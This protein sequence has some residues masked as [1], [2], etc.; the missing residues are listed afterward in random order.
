MGIIMLK[1]LST[2]AINNDFNLP[3]YHQWVKRLHLENAPHHAK[4]WEQ[5]MIYEA[6]KSHGVLKKGS[7]GIGFGV[8]TEPLVSVFAN[9]GAEVLATDQ[10]PE[11]EALAWDNGQLAKGKN[12][13]FDKRLIDK[14]KFDKNVSFEHHDMNT[15]N[16]SWVNKFDFAWSNCVIGHLGSMKLSEKH[17]V[18]HSKYIKYGGVSVLTTEL[19]ISS[20]TETVEDNSGTI[21]WRLSDL[22]RLF[23]RMLDEDMIASRFKLRLIDDE[24]DNY[25]YYEIGTNTPDG[26]YLP[27][28]YI[29]K[30]PFSNYAIVQ[31]QILFKK[32]RLTSAQRSIYRAIY[33]LD[34]ARNT[35]KLRDYI[36]NSDGDI[37]D[38]ST[39]YTSTHLGVTP[40]VKNIAL[41]AKKGEL[42]Q[43]SVM[44][45]NRSSQ[46]L[47]SYGLHTPLGVPPTVLATANPVNRDSKLYS[48]TWFSENR[49]TVT[50]EPQFDKKAFLNHSHGDHRVLPDE[51][52]VYTF[53]IQA[54]KKAGTYVEDFC[55]V[56]EGMGD[57]P[58]SHFTLSLKVK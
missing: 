43:V 32:R 17:L 9:E 29:T 13:L 54:P 2:D 3:E 34:Y 27:G 33:A 58:K 47:F 7:R 52:L 25:I 18:R 4:F 57:I 56:L 55:L 16:R 45:K 50:F 6:L 28:A 37:T 53:D 24:T 51:K 15:F 39:K 26:T 48:K 46:P 14:K 38:Y 21:I 11:D 12:S 40:T 35:Q 44:F 42:K 30:I 36:N 41:E 20:L 1:Q 5:M 22:R 19:N 10:A 8:G 23:S 49:P 31:I